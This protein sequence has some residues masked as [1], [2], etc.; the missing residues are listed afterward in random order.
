M[1]IAISQEEKDRIDE[2]YAEGKS[3]MYVGFIIGRSAQTVGKYLKES[4]Q[5]R[6]PSGRRPLALTADQRAV[7]VKLRAGN[8]P[9]AAIARRYGV[10]VETVKRAHEL[11]TTGEVLRGKKS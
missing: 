4:G 1:P 7:V 9:W 5:A 11:H 6:P 10:S 3:A 8:M 2:L